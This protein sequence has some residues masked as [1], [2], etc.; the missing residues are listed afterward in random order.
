MNILGINISHDT[1]SC[2]MI[3]GKIV[4]YFE[5][6]RL[7]KIKHCIYEESNKFY[8][9][10]NLKKYN[11]KELDYVAFSSFRRT[12]DLEDE[13]VI[14]KI[15][16]EIK[17]IGIKINEIFYNK[18]EHHLYHAY[19]GFYNSGFD[20][21]LILVCDGLGAYTDKF[22]DFRE[23]DTICY[24][25]K[26]NFNS[27]YKHV[28]NTWWGR[29]SKIKSTLNNNILFTNS[30]SCGALFCEICCKL[31]LK[32]A[33]DSG[34]LMG[35]SSY[36]KITDNNN[37]VDIID[38]FPYMND[39]CIN[40]I[41]N[42]Q[43]LSFE[44]QANIAKKVQHETKKYTIQLI[45]K[46]IEMN[47]SNNIVLSGGYF[48]NC[49]NNYEYLKE[50]PDINFYVDPICYDGGTAIGVAYFVHKILDLPFKIEPINTLYLGG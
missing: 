6:E 33:H 13:L 42:K 47:Q 17:S 8:G 4:Y 45:K 50:F 46:A 20:N 48:M 30:L 7:L 10:E 12:Y 44:D 18:E 22:I 41:K 5:D 21:A 15:I 31:N 34:K 49:V 23:V 14:N 9:I 43:F 32:G 2:L 11:I 38:G 40:N 36:G 27:I 3:D 24:A 19:N 39:E 26:N 28:S 37:W 29:D 16:N 1:S 35:M 25:N